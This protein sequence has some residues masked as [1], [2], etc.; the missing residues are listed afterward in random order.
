MTIFLF[1]YV[2]LSVN[3]TGQNRYYPCA[4]IFSETDTHTS[5]FDEYAKVYCY[6][7]IDIIQIRF[8]EKSPNEIQRKME[9]QYNDRK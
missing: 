1:R 6:R 3:V 8:S 4:F 5:F 9:K 2:Y 7:N